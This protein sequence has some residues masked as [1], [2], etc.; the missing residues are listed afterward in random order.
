MNFAA[1]KGLSQNN[2]AKNSTTSSTSGTSLSVST[3]PGVTPSNDQTQ[4]KKS[5]IVVL[6]P[7]AILFNEG[8][9]AFSLFIIQK[10]NLRLYRPKGKGFIELAVLRAG[11]VIGEMAFFAEDESERRRSCSAQAMGRTEVIEISFKAFGK[12]MSNLNPWFKTIINT[13]AS[14]LRKTNAKIKELE[15]NSVSTGYGKSASEYK[16]F[17]NVDIIRILATLFLVLKSHGEDAPNAGGL[18]IHRKTLKFY[19]LD[20]YN[21]LES[22]FEEFLT[23]LK[24]I[25]ILTIELDNDKLPNIYCF[26]RVETLRSLFI[27]FNTQRALSDDKKIKVTDKCLLLLEKVIKQIQTKEIDTPTVEVDLT[28]ILQ[29]FNDR[30]IKMDAEDLSSAQ[31]SGLAGEIIVG[32]DGSLTCPIKFHELRK[33]YLPIR[34][35]SSINKINEQKAKLK[36]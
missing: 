9:A 30:N 24:E 14:R 1:A 26:D 10:G 11:E 19:C 8:D 29:D 28:T 20:I 21:I 34:L 33:H 2:P 6:E 16:F 3:N 25:S 22:K 32:N 18:R 17:N 5:G 23:L 12:T 7:G 35:M 4:E 13:L 36:H 15:T 31:E 27:F